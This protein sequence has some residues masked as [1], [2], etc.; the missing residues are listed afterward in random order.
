MPMQNAYLLQNV[1]ILVKEG[2]LLSRAFIR[3]E[4]EVECRFTKTVHVNGIP[5]CVYAFASSSFT[6]NVLTKRKGKLA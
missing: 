3:T 5:Y 1:K 2:F 6:S 4:A